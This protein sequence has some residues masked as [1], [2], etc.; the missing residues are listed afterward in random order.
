[1]DWT[2]KLN[3]VIDYIEDHLAD[4]IDIDKCAEIACC[5][6]YHFQRMFGFTAGVTLG[7][8]IRRRRMTAAARDLVGGAKVLDTAL[9]YGYDSPTSF[10]RAFQAIHGIPPSKAGSAPLKS[11]PPLSFK[12]IIKGV[13]EMDYRIE[14]KSAIRTIGYRVELP[15]L[16]IENA[17]EAMN[18]INPFWEETAPKFEKMLKLADGDITGIM[19]ISTCND[20]QNY[21]CLTVAS[22]KPAEGD[23]VEVII[24]AV[25]WAIIPG[26]GSKDSIMELQQRIVEEWLPTSGY[27]WYKAPDIEIY[28]TYD[29]ENIEYEVWMPVVKK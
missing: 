27:E 11:Y 9:C 15:E 14:K 1:M 17:F 3:A 21:Y 23:M 12:L 5:S 29:A 25:T 6:S 4:E 19:G 2:D 10:N 7:E 24:P 16:D 13:T 28:K 22:E 20:T 18:I 26:S 8:Y